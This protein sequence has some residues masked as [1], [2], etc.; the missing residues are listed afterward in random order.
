MNTEGNQ[1]HT[2]NREYTKRRKSLVR[3]V[4]LVAAANR[5]GLLEADHGA[6]TFLIPVAQAVQ[7]GIS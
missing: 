3:Q 6:M 2:K 1:E 4:C 7:E 5:V